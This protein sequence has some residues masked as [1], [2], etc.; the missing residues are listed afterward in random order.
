MPPC[1][2]FTWSPRRWSPG[3][4]RVSRSHRMRQVFDATRARKAR[5]AGE[6][7]KV[8]GRRREVCQCAVTPCRYLSANS[9]SK[10]TIAGRSVAVEIRSTITAI[11]GARRASRAARPYGMRNHALTWGV[12]SQSADVVGTVAGAVGSSTAGSSTER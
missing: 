4:L 10:W 2:S 11:A 7:Q 6:I 9:T 1:E 12:G 8:P 5:H 3:T